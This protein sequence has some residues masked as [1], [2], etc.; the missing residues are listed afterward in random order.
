MNQEQI[1]QMLESLR[2]LALAPPTLDS[3][4]KKLSDVDPDK[5]RQ[6]RTEFEALV[7]KNRWSNSRAK[8]EAA[9]AMEDEMSDA[10]ADIPYHDEEQSLYALLEA[11][12]QRVIPLTGTVRAAWMKANGWQTEGPPMGANATRVPPILSLQGPSAAT[13]GWPSA[14]TV[15]TAERSPVR[16]P[17]NT[18]EATRDA[19]KLPYEDVATSGA[20]GGA[21]VAAATASVAPRPSSPLL[22]K[23]RVARRPPPQRPR[24]VS[25]SDRQKAPLPRT[26]TARCWECDIEGHGWA[27]CPQRRSR[28]RLA[29]QPLMRTRA[30]YVAES[31]MA[32]A[33]SRD[34]RG[35]CQ[36]VHTCQTNC[37]CFHYCPNN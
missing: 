14:P 10:V 6:W 15:Q 12:Q 18:V 7:L 27:D 28:M 30:R 26:P 34:R 17:G 9:A 31:V 32:L 21:A 36:C 1:Q 29:Q 2:Q 25:T 3:R 4:P 22:K 20:C 35:A 33:H 24:K 11:Y 37:A 16:P 23:Q 19:G 13:N 5:W 8:R